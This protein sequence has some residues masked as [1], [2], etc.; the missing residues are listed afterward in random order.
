MYFLC[1]SDCDICKDVISMA[2]VTVEILRT[3]QENRTIEKKTPGVFKKR[4][5]TLTTLYLCNDRIKSLLLQ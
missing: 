5:I 3:C 1:K 4:F 2:A